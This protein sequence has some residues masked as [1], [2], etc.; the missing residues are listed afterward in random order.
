MTLDHLTIMLPWPDSLL[1]PNRRRGNFRKF[2][3]AI[4]SARHSG[5]YAAKEALGRNQ[6]TLGARNH[7]NLIFGYPNRI[8]R[9]LDGCIGAVKHYLDGIAR[10]LGVDDQIFRPLFVDDCLDAEKR[11][12]VRIDIFSGDKDGK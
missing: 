3:P 1:F 5:F 8:K 10:A 7:V 2:Q 11:G 9:D 12:F 6:I 4:E